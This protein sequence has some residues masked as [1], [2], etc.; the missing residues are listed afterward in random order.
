M[1]IFRRM[2]YASRAAC[3]RKT[4]FVQRILLEGVSVYGN[5]KDGT[6][7]LAD[8]RCER[9][10]KDLL[11]EGKHSSTEKQLDKHMI[12]SASCAGRTSSVDV[13]AFM[14]SYEAEGKLEN[15]RPRAKHR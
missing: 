15:P 11:K 9:E 12:A 6:F 13:L 2:I 8:A 1:R 4:G 5:G 3:E 14:R 10:A 7:S